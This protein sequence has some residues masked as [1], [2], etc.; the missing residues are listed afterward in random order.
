MAEVKLQRLQWFV[1]LP[2]THASMKRQGG[3]VWDKGEAFL[4]SSREASKLFLTKRKEHRA[5]CHVIR[6]DSEGDNVDQNLKLGHVQWDEV[7]AMDL[8]KRELVAGLLNRTALRQGA[9][10][11]MYSG[12]GDT[13]ED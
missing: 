6:S 11:K 8:P 12:M 4:L 10:I 2:Q 1:R 9:T 7:Y 13:Y 5:N 3:A